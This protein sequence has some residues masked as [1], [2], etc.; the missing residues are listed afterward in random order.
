[1]VGSFS[2]THAD[3]FFLHTHADGAL[4]SGH[5]ENPIGGDPGQHSHQ[6]AMGKRPLDMEDPSLEIA[7]GSTKK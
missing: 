2:H 6:R 4:N 1:M 5:L 7:I 3:R